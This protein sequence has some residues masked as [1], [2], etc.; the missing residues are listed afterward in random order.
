MPAK[1]ANSEGRWCENMISEEPSSRLRLLTVSGNR[2]ICRSLQHWCHH[3]V[4][5]WPEG[6]NQ[7]I[8]IVVLSSAQNRTG[9]G[10]KFV[11]RKNTMLHYRDPGEMPLYDR[12][13][14]RST[15]A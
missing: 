7:V 1:M 6:R 15:H 14:G 3:C 8:K 5:I 2:P 10:A 4:R 9:N 12:T 11:E 13:A